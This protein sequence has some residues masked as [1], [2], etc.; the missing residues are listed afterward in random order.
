MLYEV[1]GVSEVLARKR[2]SLRRSKFPLPR[3]LQREDVIIMNASE[4]REMTL[5]QLNEL[6]FGFKRRTI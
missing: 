6:L 4:L 2:F 3:P 5:D 1:Q